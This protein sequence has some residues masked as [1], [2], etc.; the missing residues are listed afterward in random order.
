M[1][2]KIRMTIDEKILKQ[3]FLYTFM[4]GLVAH[5]YCFLNLMV[6]H[7]SLNDFFV[8]DKWERASFGRIFYSIYIS[9][10]RGRIV[11]PW[12]IGILTLCWI[13]IAVYFI[14]KMFCIKKSGLILLVSGICVTNPTVYALSATYIHDL[15]A[16]MLA[17]MLSVAAVYLWSKAI[18]K[19]GDKKSVFV[20][21]LLA[22]ALQSI[23]L[24]IYQSYI[25]L[26]ITLIVIIS[27]KDLLREKECKDV[28]SNGF[29]GI[30]MLIVAAILYL[31]ELKIFEVL[32]GI[33]TMNSQTYNG[34]GNLSQILTGN[35]FGNIVNTYKSFLDAFKKLILTSYPENISLM[36]HAVFVVCIAVISITGISKIEWKSKILFVVLALLMPFGMNTTYFLSNGVG[37]ILT[38]YAIWMLYLLGLV[39]VLWMEKA[40]AMSASAKKWIY[41]IALGCL[42]L[43]VG[44][45][46]QTSNTIYMKKDLEYQSTLSYMT[47]VVDRIEEYPEY[48][49][50]ETPVMF[51]G[52]KVQGITRSG[53][54]RY[55]VITGVNSTSSIT[56]YDVYE[57]YFEYVLG[58]PISFHYDEAFKNDERVIQMPSF[59]QGGS[60][61]MIDGVLMVKLSGYQ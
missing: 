49:P 23:T 6:S 16:D 43:T 2:E 27:M 11:L 10:T 30:A 58:R 34:V 45:N 31:F 52:E 55:S 24:G 9:L 17:M 44:E 3:S 29:Y 57:D 36:I 50:G 12:L 35:V 4:I 61:E 39:L 40:E 59:P 8:S 37:H 5:G 38:Q 42:C 19:K 26:T 20:A 21:L 47:R 41:I 33:S 32:T 7:D 18:E 54:E 25:S 46:I 15:D 53:F 60:V 22:A 56:Y 48:I 13:S 1:R 28:L 51:I 14:V